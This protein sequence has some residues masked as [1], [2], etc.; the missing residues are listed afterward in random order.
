MNRLDLILPG[1]T[2]PFGAQQT[3]DIHAHLKQPEFHALNR[4]VSRATCTQ[5]DAVDF[6]STLQQ[7]ICPQCELGICEL[8]ARFSNIDTVTGFLYRADPVHFRAES[9]HA[10]LIG[11]EMLDVQSSE[12]GLLI[13]AF[14]E[15]F[16]Q[17]K[18]SL[19]ADD[20]GH[21]YLRCEKPLDLQFN[22]LDYSLGRDIK[23]FMP[24]GNDELWWRRIVNEAQMLFFQHD[25]NQHREMNAQLTIN[26][27]WLW[28]KKF[29]SISSSNDYSCLYSQHVLANCM[30][31]Q[32][33]LDVKS[34]DEISQA[35]SIQGDAV[36]VIDDLY[37]SVC[38]GDVDAWFD[39]L[40]EFSDGPVKIFSDL[41][42][43]G[44]IHSMNI[45][46]CDSQ[47]FNISKY[48]SYKFWQP[49]KTLDSFFLVSES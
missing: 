2:G 35:A 12:S 24:T 31:S 39:A 30:A 5:I 11:T 45:Y 46:T 49:V 9:D 47:V 34:I 21:W 22:A 23:H 28:D 27:L 38:Y 42:K 3:D 8:S 14:N 41:L 32:S 17:D 10:V 4:L 7:L 15:H 36:M 26:G 6:Y 18:I 44:D 19:L 20:L 43:S 48:Q 16:M 25:V 40:T 1:L 33:K 37:S 29:D 13:D